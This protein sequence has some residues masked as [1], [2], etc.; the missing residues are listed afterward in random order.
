NLGTILG[1]Q[2]QLTGKVS[3]TSGSPTFCVQLS[4]DGGSTWTAAKQTPL[5]TTTVSTYVL[6]GTSD[7]WG[8]AWTT[9]NFGSGLRVRFID[10]AGPSSLTF[11]L[12]SV[13]VAVTYQ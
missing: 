7:T 2:V 4:S 11:A 10:A 13:G 1:I 5:L 12:D 9:A 6:G 8:R 3:G